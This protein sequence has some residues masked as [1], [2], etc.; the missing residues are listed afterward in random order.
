MPIRYWAAVGALVALVLGASLWFGRNS[1][2]PAPLEFLT[3][4][5]AQETITVHVSGEV[6]APGLVVVAGDARVADAVAAAGGS[7]ITAD[8][9][10][11]NL[12]A[13]V[14]DGEQIVV[15]DNTA[16]PAGDGA[17]AD[18]RI[19][20]NQASAAELEN[21]ARRWSGAGAAN[22]SA[23]RGQRPLPSR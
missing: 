11:L 6:V 18:G 4:R 20:I 3:D 9:G 7:T 15:P 21:P 17:S 2:E 8:L 13:P 16:Q 23:S 5:A 12:A 22:R 10:G 14:R 19:R 1:P